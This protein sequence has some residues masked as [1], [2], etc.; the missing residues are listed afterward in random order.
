MLVESVVNAMLL[1][2]CY[3]CLMGSDPQQCHDSP[4]CKNLPGAG[5]KLPDLKKEPP[6][7][8][9]KLAEDN[10]L[11]V[12]K[13]PK[14]IKGCPPLVLAPET[15]VTRITAEKMLEYKTH[16]KETFQN[17][18][19]LLH[20]PDWAPFQSIA[21]VGDVK[22]LQTPSFGKL[23]GFTMEVNAKPCVL[24]LDVMEL[25]MNP[26]IKTKEL[27]MKIDDVTG[28]AYMTAPAYPMIQARD[29]VDLYLATEED[30]KYYFTFSN[31]EGIKPSA[32]G[33]TRA[34]NRDSGIF[35][36]PVYVD[37]ELK[38]NLTWIINNDYKLGT[39]LQSL[40]QVMFPQNMQK[41]MMYINEVVSNKTY[42]MD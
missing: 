26:T 36:D 30:G 38:T 41:M 5:K 33:F 4:M 19:E 23:W 11:F 18:Q 22:T 25:L 3:I 20:D 31:I 6:V 17:F 28:I 8:K 24:I 39:F 21:G 35:M 16:A 9:R 37:N 2:N 15:P 1:V 10:N 7:A 40:A 14:I 32:P 13:K 12:P 27:L 34:L 29:F 42:T